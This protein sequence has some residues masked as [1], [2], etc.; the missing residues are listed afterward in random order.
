MLLARFFTY[1][2]AYFVTDRHL[3]S[4]LR[5]VFISLAV[6]VMD[7]YLNDCSGAE[8]EGKNELKFVYA[9]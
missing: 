8:Q 9:V 3:S 1:E 6:L 5:K 2:S 7:L 4:M